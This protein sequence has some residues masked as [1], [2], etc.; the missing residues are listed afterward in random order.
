[1]NVMKGISSQGSITAKLTA[2]FVLFGFVPMAVVGLIAYNAGLTIEG[3]VGTRF[4]SV[5][6]GV[7]DKIDRNLFE[8]Y[9]DVQ[10]FDFNHVLDPI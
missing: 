3:S 10:A 8:R 9:G 6:E 5:A 2:L 4:Q 7:A 1:M